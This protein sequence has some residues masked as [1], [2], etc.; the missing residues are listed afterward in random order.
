MYCD[1]ECTDHALKISG[2]VSLIYSPGVDL[3]QT[4]GIPKGFKNM[5]SIK[6]TIWSSKK[7]AAV[8]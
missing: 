8:F 6:F 7:N 4:R 5:H 3:N 2:F 1:F